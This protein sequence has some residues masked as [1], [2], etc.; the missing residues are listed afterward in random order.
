MFKQKVLVLDPIPFRGGSKVATEN[1][2]NLIDKNAND[3]FVMTR[4]DA[5]WQLSGVQRVSFWVPAL[6]VQSTQGIPYF[7][8]HVILMMNIMLFVLRYGRA[9]K[10]IGASGPGVDLSLYLYK[11]LFDVC[12]VQLIH[13]PVAA[14]R[15]I[16]RC[17]AAADHVFYLQNC[18]RS[19]LLALGKVDDAKHLSDDKFSVMLNGIAKHQWPSPR[20]AQQPAIFWAASLLKWKGLET[21]LSALTEFD[22]ARRPMTHI[23]YIRPEDMALP[24][25]LAPVAIPHVV[26]HESPPELDKFRKR[27]SIFVSTSV[28]EPFGLSI[29]EALAA[30]LCVLIPRDGAYWDQVLIDGVSCIKYLPGEPEDLHVKLQALLA[31]P[32]DIMN[33]GDKGREIAGCYQAETCYRNIV[34][35]VEKSVIHGDTLESSG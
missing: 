12:V 7:L 35:Y 9:N 25:S 2:I 19:L 16:G 6:L 27:S 1:I 18:R 31:E 8:R 22:D 3:V 14:S 5:S 32:S 21:L 13:G 34:K 26:W 20:I 24:V 29:L 23:C 4:D 10:M 30:G 17:L 33:I 28:N 11:A 15:T